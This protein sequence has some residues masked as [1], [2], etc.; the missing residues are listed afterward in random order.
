VPRHPVSFQYS[1]SYGPVYVRRIELAGENREPRG[2]CRPA[3]CASS[4]SRRVDARRWSLTPRRERERPAHRALKSAGRG[5]GFAGCGLAWT[6]CYCWLTCHCQCRRHLINQTT[7]S[8]GPGSHHLSVHR[9][10]LVALGAL[11]AAVR[12]LQYAGS[13]P[14]RRTGGR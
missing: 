11:P 2:Y 12:D 9:L 14:N 3:V 8:H 7:Q 4:S 10:R 5:G 1:A 6:R 13:A